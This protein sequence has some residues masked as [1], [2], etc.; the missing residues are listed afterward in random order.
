MR[1]TPILA[2]IFFVM[3]VS[4]CTAQDQSPKAMAETFF[5]TLQGG[6]ISQAYDQL[7][8]GSTIPQTKPQAVEAVKRQTESGLPQLGKILGFELIREEKFGT[9]IVRFVYLL[10]LEKSPTV[11]ELY[12]YKPKTAW[13]IVNLMFNDQFNLLDAKQ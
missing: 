1:R 11:W 3:L 2:I 8:A 13:F 7:F 10:K 6:K 4:V 9:T 12:F 5:R